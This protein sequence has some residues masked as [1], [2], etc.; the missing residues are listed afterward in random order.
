VDRWGT[1]ASLQDS[2]KDNHEVKY[3]L[4]A[5]LGSVYL[6]GCS[7]CLEEEMF[8]DLTGLCAE[9]NDLAEWLGI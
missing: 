6:P 8:Y 3:N 4:W 9:A 1:T 2:P 7:L 5:E